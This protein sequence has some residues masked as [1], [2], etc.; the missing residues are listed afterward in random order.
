MR[1]SVTIQKNPF[2]DIR[3][4]LLSSGSRRKLFKSVEVCL[5]RRAQDNAR[6]YGGKKFWPAIANSVSSQS[7]ENGLIVGSS[8]F[9][10]AHKHFGGR[11]SAPGKGPMSKGRKNLTIP[12][13]EQA[14]RKNASDF[15]GLWC[16]KAR[17]GNLF[18][19]RSEKVRTGTKKEITEMLRESG[20]FSK[21]NLK[22]HMWKTKLI[23]YFLLVKEVDQKAYPW[24]PLDKV[25]EAEVKRGVNIWKSAIRKGGN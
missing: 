14:R 8:H 16:Y 25:A 21:K 3:T 4:D 17:S 18:L 22:R 15:N 10:A 12:V 2:G 7:D 23:F 19:V 20:H 6:A 5:K 11:I 24:F 1:T 9:A 13:N